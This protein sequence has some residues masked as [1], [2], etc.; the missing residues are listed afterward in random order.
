MKFSKGIFLVTLLAALLLVLHG[1]AQ[2]NTQTKAATSPEAQANEKN[3]Q[4]YIDLLRSDVRQQK[5]EMMGAMMV[6]GAQ[7]AAKFW[8][9]YSDYDAQLTKLNDQRVES[10][11]R[12]RRLL[13]P[14][15]RRQ[16]RRVGSEIARLS[17]PARRAPCANL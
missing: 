2:A 14:D 1:R 15:D 10:I 17:K 13:R 11:N 5:A 8:P 6:L 3:L 16:G 7:D 12:I 4:E 9:I